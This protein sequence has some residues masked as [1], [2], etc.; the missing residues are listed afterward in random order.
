MKFAINKRDITPD[1]PF[2]QAGYAARK[3]VWTDVH[4]KLYAT[5][6]VI[7]A[8]QRAVIVTLD[9]LYGDRSFEE[10]LYTALGDRFGVPA[11]NIILSYTHTHGALTTGMAGHRYRNRVIDIV[12]ELTGAGIDGPGESELTFYRA[13]SDF[14]ISRRLP[15]AEGIQLRPNPD[16]AAADYD[17]LILKFEGEARGILYS[18]AC[19]ATCCGG[20]NLSITADYPGA[21][22]AILEEKYGCG[23]MF[24]QGCGADINP[25]IAARDGH[26]IGLTAAEMTEAS[27]RL[28]DDIINALEGGEGRPVDADIRAVSE[29]IGLPCVKWDRDDW[30]KIAFALSEPEYRRASARRAIDRYN[31][32]GL[33]DTLPFRVKCVSLGD[34]LR[35]VCLENEVVSAYG[36]R[37]KAAVG[38]DTVTLGYTGRACCYIPTAAILREGGYECDS[39]LGAGTAGPFEESLEPLICDTAVR[40]AGEVER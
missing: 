15:S 25:V 29:M 12:C 10:A 20:G 36:K 34:N 16:P 5:V 38:G 23:V 40:L 7:E 11:D 14:G 6:A 17:L 37:I 2:V 19:H 31:I 28:A 24:L 35:F 8:G 21:V 4:D 1:F 26:F 3:E 22:R 39:F 33:T 27:A 9:L 32:G 13:S 30:K 18:C